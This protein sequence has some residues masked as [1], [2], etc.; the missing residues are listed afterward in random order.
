MSVDDAAAALGLPP[1]EA[2]AL[3]ESAVARVAEATG[4]PT[5]VRPLS[6][7]SRAD[8]DRECLAAW[9]AYD[10]ELA[11]RYTSYFDRHP[12]LRG[13][14]RYSARDLPSA[15]PPGWAELAS[16]IPP[17]ERHRHHL[18]AKSSQTLALGLLG[19][20]AR[21]DPSLQWLWE[22]LSPL[23]P[24][25]LGLPRMAFEQ[26]LDASL[27]EEQ[28]RQTTIDVLVDD[29]SVLICIEAK[30][31]EDGIGTCSCGPDGGNPLEGRCASRVE[32]RPA[33]WRAARELLGLP[34]REPPG[35][36]PISAAYQAVRSAAAARALAGP[37]RL[38]VFALVYSKDNPYFAATGAWPGWP[39]VLAEAVAEHA[40]P[41]H[42][43]FAAISW[44]EL[45]PLLALDDEARSWASEKHGLG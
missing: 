30:W 19:V 29:P 21:L 13:T 1:E 40:D 33:Y 2:S 44:Q 11:D 15:L 23:P 3:H 5:E 9:R 20:S 18:S 27:L 12:E 14:Q 37:D 24:A 39:S 43:R 45:M 8:I 4:L 42:F 25:E 7:W 22:A 32:Q 34:D 10:A 6:A 16:L 17:A 41:S 35:P 28:P 26:S 36:C 38:A 31:R